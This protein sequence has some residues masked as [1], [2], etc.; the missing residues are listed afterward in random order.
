MST[1]NRFPP[2]TDTCIYRGMPNKLKNATRWQFA[3]YYLI[4][5]Y[6][7]ISNC[8]LKITYIV[9]EWTNK[10]DNVFQLATWWQTVTRIQMIK[11]KTNSNSPSSILYVQTRQKENSGLDQRA[12]GPSGGCGMWAAGRWAFMSPV[13]AAVGL[14]LAK[15]D[16]VERD[17]KLGVRVTNF[18]SRF[19]FA[20]RTTD[21]RH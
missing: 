4:Y 14:L 18:F 17:R 8:G 6:F 11:W 20:S 7:S 2:D 5:H 13:R 10:H 1:A 3:I 19:S 21:N 9:W 12:S 15:P 16:S